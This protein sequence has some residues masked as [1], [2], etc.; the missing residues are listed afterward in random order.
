MMAVMTALAQRIASLDAP[1]LFSLSPVASL[2][3]HA[4]LPE[5][6]LERSLCILEELPDQTAGILISYRD[7]LVYGSGGVAALEAIYEVARELGL[8]I[9]SDIGCVQSFSDI[10][11]V[12]R[13]FSWL[14]APSPPWLVPSWQAAVSWGVSVSRAH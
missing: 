3:M 13:G 11:A 14:L 12:C 1:I 4:D 6:L 5:E 7:F 10:P 8:F 9:V 2:E